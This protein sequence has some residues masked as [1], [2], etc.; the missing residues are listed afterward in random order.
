MRTI[1]LNQMELIEGGDF[2]G[3]FCKGFAAGAVV[4]EAGVLANIWNPAGQAGLVA[5]VSVSAACILI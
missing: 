5:L 4:Y 3:S 1:E 2:W